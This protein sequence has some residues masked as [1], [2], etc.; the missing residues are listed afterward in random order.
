[1]NVIRM[2]RVHSRLA[3]EDDEDQAETVEGRQKCGQKPQH[4]QSLAQR[5]G[6]PGLDQERVFTEPPGST[7]KP[8]QGERPS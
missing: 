3:P 8:G 5:A 7:R 1:M 6:C 4:S 2:M